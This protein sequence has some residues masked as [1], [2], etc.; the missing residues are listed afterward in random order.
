MGFHTTT[1]YYQAGRNLQIETGT[2]YIIL[3][4]IPCKV[5]TI[6]NPS[7]DTLLVKHH[8]I[9]FAVLGKSYFDVFGI[10]NLT[11]LSLK[12]DTDAVSIVYIRWLD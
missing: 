9:D 1:N 7:E 6:S 3:P 8:N 12:Y 11:E 2:D 10:D 5:A 4:N